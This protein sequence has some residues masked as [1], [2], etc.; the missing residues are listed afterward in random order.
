[1]AIYAF[2]KFKFGLGRN[3]HGTTR[4]YKHIVA[5]VEAKK[6]WII[7]GVYLS[8]LAL[9]SVQLGYCCCWLRFFKGRPG[10]ILKAPFFI[11]K[12]VVNGLRYPHLILVVL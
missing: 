6:I 9:I 2:L 10:I 7:L 11:V 1:M 4:L 5:F 3:V 8:G 12:I